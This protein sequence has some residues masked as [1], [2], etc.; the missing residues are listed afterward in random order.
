[1]GDVRRPVSPDAIGN[2]VLF[3]VLGAL[4]RHLSA[5]AGGIVAAWRSL[6]RGGSS[7]QTERISAS[8]TASGCSVVAFLD[9]APDTADGVL[10][11][12]RADVEQTFGAEH[13]ARALP[14]LQ[15]AI[16]D[17]AGFYN[18]LILFRSG[19]EASVAVHGLGVPV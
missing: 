3:G 2:S 9:R 14:E 13:A 10:Q 8:L 12:V 1:M 7:W 11:I 19:G 15:R 4:P 5:Q 6:G 17:A 18:Q 16:H